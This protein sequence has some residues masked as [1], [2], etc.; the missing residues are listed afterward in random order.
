MISKIYAESEGNT[1]VLGL[2]V[3]LRQINAFSDN[4][5]DIEKQPVLET[6]KVSD[7]YWKWLLYQFL[8]NKNLSTTKLNSIYSE[9]ML[10]ET[11]TYITELV[12]SEI[13]EEIGN[14]TYTLNN[15]V[16]PNIENWLAN[17]NI[18]N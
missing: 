10:A 11:A 17:N 5:I 18:L 12:N 9:R 2:Q 13:L 16:K 15:V 14:D 3:W 1:L 8:I 6:L 7:A 4:K